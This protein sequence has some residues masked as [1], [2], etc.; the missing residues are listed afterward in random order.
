MRPTHAGTAPPSRRRGPWRA[1][2]GTLGAGL[3]LTAVAAV[4]VV[5]SD[6]PTPLGV[7]LLLAALC[8]TAL[9]VLV[10]GALRLR[11]GSDGAGDRG[12]TVHLWLCLVADHGFV[13]VPATADAP[14]HWRCRRCGKRRYTRPRSAGETLNATQAEGLWIRRDDLPGD[15]R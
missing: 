4:L 14:E 12:P 8:L 3:A 13:R 15:R 2:A 1:G 11:E 6:D 5:R 7:G 9:Y 10:I